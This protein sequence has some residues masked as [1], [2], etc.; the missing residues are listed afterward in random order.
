MTRRFL[1]TLIVAG[2]AFAGGFTASAVLD[3]RAA[4]A[5]P[6]SPLPPPPTQADRPPNPSQERFEQVIYRVGPSVVS[7]DAVKP[8]APPTAAGKAKPTEESGS[9]VIVKLDGGRGYYAVSNN[10]VVGG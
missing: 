4:V 2:G 7:V 10:H 3:P 8:S 1:Y 6:G 9:G 5:Q